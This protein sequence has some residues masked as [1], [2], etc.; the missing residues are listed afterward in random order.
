M[1]NRLVMVAASGVAGPS[2]SVEMVKFDGATWFDFNTTQVYTD[3]KVGIFSCWV[4][5]DI[6][7]ANDNNNLFYIKKGET[8]LAF[9]IRLNANNEVQVFG[10]QTGSSNIAIN[11]VTDLLT[12]GVNMYDGEAHHILAAWDLANTYGQILVDG[13]ETIYTAGTLNNVL[14]DYSGTQDFFMAGGI[15]GVGSGFQKWFG[16]VGQYY[17]NLEETIDISV[18]ANLD[19]FWVDGP[20]SLG[21]NGEIPTGNSPLVFFNNDETTFNT[22]LGTETEPFI[23]NGGPLTAGTDL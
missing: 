16:E 21:T 10:L 22:N 18:Q 2:A 20:V 15:T 7:G 19:K 9:L 14:I 3:A 13:A 12:A 11:L 17:L 4:R 8:T 5:P 23:L 1:I 6:A